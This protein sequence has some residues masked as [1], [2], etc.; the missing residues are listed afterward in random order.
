MRYI[1]IL[2]LF[3]TLSWAQNLEAFAK[4]HHYETDYKVALQKAKAQKKEIFFVMATNYCPWCRKYE[5]RTL[6]HAAVDKAI[7]KDYIALIL[8]REK[9][10]FPDRFQTPIVPVTYFVDYKDGSIVTKEVGFKAKKE[11]LELLNIR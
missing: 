1:L 3:V 10:D 8:N 11:L 6:S 9:G 7:H 2:T 4:K 5:K